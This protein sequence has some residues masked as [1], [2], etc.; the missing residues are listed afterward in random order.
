MRSLLLAKGLMV[1]KF[2]FKNIYDL[3]RYILPGHIYID[4]S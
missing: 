1:V 2:K 4:S 3:I